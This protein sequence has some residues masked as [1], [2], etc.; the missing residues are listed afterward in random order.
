MKKKRL[1][2]IGIPETHVKRTIERVKKLGYEVIVGDTPSNLSKY[3]NLIEKADQQVA[4]DYTDYLDLSKVTKMLQEEEPLDAI[5]TF[6]EMGLI[7]T[8]KVIQ[9]YGLL[10]NKT[11]IIEACNNKFITRNLLK[12]AGLIG[13]EYAICETI[14]DVKNFYEKVSGTIIIKPH[15]LQGSLGVFKIEKKDEIEPTFNECLKISKEPIVLVEE[16]IDGQE[17]SIEAIVYHGE[18]IIFGI[19]E[20]LLYQDTFVEA[21]HISPYEKAEF[22]FDEYKKIVQKIVEAIGITF[23]PLHIEGFITNKGL[24]VGEVH[25]RY[26]G[27]NITTLTELALKCDMTTPIFAELGNITY[28]INFGEPKEVAAIR[29]I[30]VKPGVVLKIEGI[31]EIKQ[32]PEVVDLEISCQPDDIIKEIKSNFDRVGWVL[33]KTSSREKVEEVFSRVFST[34]KIIT[35]GD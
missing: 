29:F 33:I 28:D 5:F 18:V 15:N 11:E 10:G 21:G 35:K 9:E 25:T 12:K 2:F 30:D 31:E 19:T 4:T 7:A 27:D 22:P 32:I 6:K 16:F 3:A 23:G 1:F 14:N 13:P 8:S 17:I 34:L 26:G 20:K 24:I